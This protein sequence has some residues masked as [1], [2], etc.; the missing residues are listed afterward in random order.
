MDLTPSAQLQGQAAAPL[1]DVTM[2]F[3][4]VEG[5]A[6]FLSR[7]NRNEIHILHKV[8]SLLELL[9]TLLLLLSWAI[10]CAEHVGHQ[11]AL[12]ACTSGVSIACRHSF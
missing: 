6:G 2:V 3:I 12:V 5:A 7:H 11:L 9:W 10:S 8:G 1:P 4:S